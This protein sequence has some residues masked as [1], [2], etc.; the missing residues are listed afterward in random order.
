M[1]I[2]PLAIFTA[3]AIFATALVGTGTWLQ[4][5][6]ENTITACANK[7]T[8][9]MRYLTKGKCNKK[10]EN[11][12]SWNTTGPI[13]PRG[14][15]GEVGLTGTKGETGERGESGINVNLVDASGKELGPWSYAGGDGNHTFVA[16]DGGIWTVSA[17]YYGFTQSTARYFRDS[18][19]SMPLLLA[20]TFSSSPPPSTRWVL[21]S[22]DR[23]SVLTGHKAK[24]GVKSFR[25]SELAGVYMRQGISPFSCFNDKNRAGNTLGDY[26]SVYFW[27][28]E[29]VS[30]PTYTP[31]LSVH[32]G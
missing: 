11:N 19:C 26:S 1:N 3:G 20:D 12:V 14:A 7:K 21:Y 15:T 6:S 24:S 8:G 5:S 22:D 31:P 29:E 18:N 32:V 13:G 16:P 25:G 27:D 30:L 17:E 23:L 10:T 4:A 28:A 2:R 9:T